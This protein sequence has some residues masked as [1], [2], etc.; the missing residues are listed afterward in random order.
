MKKCF[1]LGAALLMGASLCAFAACDEGEPND[2]GG[3]GTGSASAFRMAGDLQALYGENGYPQAVLVAKKSLIEGDAAAVGTLVSYMEGSAEYLASCSAQTVVD[4]LAPYYTQG[5]TP[6]L[7]AK[8]LTKEVISHCSVAY[9]STAEEAT[10][11]RVDNYLAEML[12]VDE[13]AAKKVAEAF[14]YTGTVQAGTSD[15]SYTV[16]APD[17]A[18]ALAL[19]NAIAKQ[20]EGETFDFHIVASDTIGA[21]VTNADAAKNADF[22][23][24]PVNAAA[25]ALGT[26]EKYQML[27]VVTN[28]NIYFLTTGDNA[29]LTKD[30]LSSLKGKTMGVV[31]L[32]NVPGL[33]LRAVLE[34]YG[35]PYQI[36]SN[37]SEPAAD[38]LNLKAMTPDN[39]TPA[40]GCDY[41]LCPEPAASAKIAATAGK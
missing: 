12:E 38:K 10:R 36:L 16:Y 11:T 22:C 29:A 3:A 17:G 28:G 31:Q 2:D 40:S 30:N 6:S 25:K 9:H 32:P 39:V 13:S 7:N 1:V 41:Y 35:V 15:K 4:A 23:I 34:K 20:G 26:G 37:D 19:A 5:M 18:P 27:G 33:T 21:Q 14:Y 24:M 8:N